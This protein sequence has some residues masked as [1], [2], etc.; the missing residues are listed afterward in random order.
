MWN[1]VGIVRSNRRLA[2]AWKRI[3]LLQEEIRNYYWDFHIT[4]DLIELRN[5]AVVAEL[6]IQSA[7]RRTESRGLHYN[8]DYPERDDVHWRHDT[9]VL[10]GQP[11]EPDAEFQASLQPLRQRP[12]LSG[13]PRT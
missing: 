2:R 4:G 1:Y 7:I 6:I 11:F 13:Q 10:P 9:V 5:I 8:I 3:T 12:A